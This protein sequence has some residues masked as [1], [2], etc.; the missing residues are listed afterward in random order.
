M[1]RTICRIQTQQKTQY[2][3]IVN[4][5]LTRYMMLFI[6]HVHV[7]TQ[8]IYKDTKRREGPVI[9]HACPFTA[10]RREGL[11]INHACPFYHSL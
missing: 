1:S 3:N 8:T 11:V 9:N 2:I 10:Y 6:H 7:H 5:Y 4:N